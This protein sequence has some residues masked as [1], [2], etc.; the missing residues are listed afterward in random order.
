M[1]N[2]DNKCEI[3]HFNCKYGRDF[4]D[5]IYNINNNDIVLKRKYERYKNYDNKKFRNI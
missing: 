2:K 1:K 5:I 3:S 4:L